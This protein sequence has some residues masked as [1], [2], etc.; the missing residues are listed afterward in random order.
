MAATSALFS[1][2]ADPAAAAPPGFDSRLLVKLVSPSTDGT[3]IAAEAT[4]LA[5]VPVSYGAAVSPEWHAI[6]LHCA[7]ASACGE[8]IGRLRRSGVYG[9]VE[10]DGRKRAVM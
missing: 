9:S 4:R 3:A 2:C 8:A 10:T 5:G 1:A 7:D 6:S